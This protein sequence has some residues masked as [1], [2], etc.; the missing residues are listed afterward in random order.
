M[1]A[2]VVFPNGCGHEAEGRPCLQGAEK[3][4]CD[5]M[6]ITTQTMHSSGDDVVIGEVT[7]RDS[8]LPLEQA[9]GD[10]VLEK[11]WDCYHC[12]RAARYVPDIDRFWAMGG[13]ALLESELAESEMPSPPL[14]QLDSSLPYDSS[15]GLPDH[16][17]D[18]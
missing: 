18:Y 10:S 15:W 16:L 7:D 4:I 6:H 12:G 3:M 13:M 2:D 14:E 1:A 17:Q 9:V 11:C 5:R 8:G